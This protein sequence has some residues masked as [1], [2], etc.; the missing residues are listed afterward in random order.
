MTNRRKIAVVDDDESIRDSL[1]GLLES[2]GFEATPFASAEDLLGSGAIDAFD[3]LIL[4]ISMP[5]M[6]G[7]ELQRHLA[8]QARLTP[9]IFI[10]A[11]AEVSGSA[12]L[13]AQGAV[14]FLHKPFS[15]SAIVGAVR[16]ALN[17]E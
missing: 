7:L 16:T 2:F 9:I 8:R 17:L 3:C 5:G 15:E 12:H 13:S 11:H 10:T 6:S 14:A 4:D 1:P